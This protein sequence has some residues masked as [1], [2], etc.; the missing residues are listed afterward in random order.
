MSDAMYEPFEHQ[1][2]TTDFIKQQPR[3]LITSDPGTGKTR[4]VLDAIVGRESRILVL[5]PLSILEASWG[6][7]IDKFQPELTY[8]IAYA[9][10][11]EAAFKSNARVVITN[12]D[13]VKWI[14]KNAHV[15][16][17]FDTLVIDEFT[18]FKN[19][20]SQRSK[21]CY[22]IA[23][24]FDHRIAMSGTPNSNGI[25]DVWHP[26]LIVDDGQR[27]GHRFYSFRSSVCTPR[28]NG[29]ANEW[30]Q[31]EN[32]EEVVAAALSDINIR[33]ELTECIDMPEQSIQTMFVTLP[34]KI[35]QQYRT[36]SEDS[37]L[38]TGAA[39]INAVHA[40]SKVK[41]LLQLCTGAVYDEHGDTQR[42]H[43][44]RYD[45]VMQLVSERA[46]TLVAFNWKHEQRY[47]AEL[48]DKLGLAHATIDGS[49]AAPKRKEIVDR[50]QAGQLQVVFCHPQSAGHGLT[51]TKAKTIIWASPTY[52]A[53]HY[54]QFN[55]RIY[56]A[57]QTEKTE[58]IQ[59]AARDTW[60]TDVYEKL[61]SKVDRMDELLGILN[62]LKPAA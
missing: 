12:H 18:A 61:Q 54:Q 11:R 4:S 30:V 15:L 7:D 10:N 50:L 24:A 47:M 43:K 44:E 45:L 56:R 36:L 26:T 39:T 6:D 52:N 55:R 29:F 31:K 60:E 34:K 8:A 9:K 38:Y 40:G 1:K 35:M 59:I 21:A 46:Q 62:N 28:F 16:E 25:L 33:Y 3:C 5:A 14:A 27:L 17:N 37:V 32:A 41:K 22:K 53:E 13:A 2:V 49:T 42:I 57:G 19:K 23:Q 48:A 58:V 51:M 20:D